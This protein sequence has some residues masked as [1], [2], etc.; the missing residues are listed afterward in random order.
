MVRLDGVVAVDAASYLIA[1]GMIAAIAALTGPER[2]PPADVAT[3]A[4]TW[5]AVWREWL[6]GLRLIRDNQVL[7]VVFGVFAI[8]SLGEGVMQTAFGSWST[9]HWGR[10]AGG[11]LAAER[12]GGRGPGGGRGGRVWGKTRTP[13]FLLGWEITDLATFNYRRSC[14]GSG[15]G[16]C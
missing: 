11:R 10:R 1:A 2:Q 3:V 15:S 8:T 4:E 6:A 7:R 16:W 5:A 14:R 9:R 12:P 13:V